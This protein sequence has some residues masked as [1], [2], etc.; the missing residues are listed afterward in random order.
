MTLLLPEATFD[1]LFVIDRLQRLRPSVPPSEIHLFAYLGCLLW[2]YQRRQASDW[3]YP[4]IASEMGAPFSQEIG[5]ALKGLT[6]RGYLGRERE[7]VRSTGLAE[8]TLSVLASLEL[9]QDRAE[10]LDAACACTAAFSVGIVG[11]AL[12]H[13]PDL[14]RSKGMPSTRFLLEDNARTKLYQQFDALRSS[15]KERTTD[16]RLPGRSVV[17]S[18]API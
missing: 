14:S 4:F 15:L 12:E 9:N 17:I 10:C 6:E 1:C 13:E 2:M 8:S 5:N 7:H 16:L 18:A 11:S 3:G